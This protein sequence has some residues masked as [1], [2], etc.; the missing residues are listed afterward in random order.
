MTS[1]HIANRNQID[2]YIGKWVFYFKTFQMGVFLKHHLNYIL[3]L[4]CWPSLS[5]ERHGEAPQSKFTMHVNS[6][7][8]RATQTLQSSILAL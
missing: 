4:E 2:Y 5:L 1:V 6:H 7:F 8:D 3:V